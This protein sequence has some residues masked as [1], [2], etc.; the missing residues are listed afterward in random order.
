MKS[1]LSLSTD[2]KSASEGEYIEIKW[3]CDA[4]PDSLYLAI[5]SGCT[6]YSIAVSDSGTTRIP[7]P[8]SN[9]KMTVKLIGVISG[10]KVT[11][12]IDVR[13]KTTRKARTKAPLSSQMKMFGEKMQAKWYVFR[14]QCKYWWLSQKKWQKVLW[15]VLLALWLGM[16]IASFTN[17][18]SQVVSSDQVQTAYTF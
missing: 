17:N 6:Q 9:G 12:S 18:T 16:L 5:N 7:V 11:E 8:R 13:V 2:R 1:K 10:K 3:T 14:A 4:C 15:I